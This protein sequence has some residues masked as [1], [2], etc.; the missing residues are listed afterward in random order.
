MTGTNIDVCV[1]GSFMM[2]FVVRTPRRPGLGET[3]V[4]T[5]FELCLGGKGFNQAVAAA[6]SGAATAMVGRVGDDDFGRDFLACLEREGIES[7]VP[8]DTSLGTG[9]GAPVVDANGDNAIVIV[10]RANLAVTTSQIEDASAL[11]ADARVLLLQLEL[12]RDAAVAAA[13]IAREAGTVV[14]LN[15]A[16]AIDGIE[17]FAGLVDVL[18]PNEAEALTL[19][20]GTDVG[21]T[22]IEVGEH[23]RTTLG[24]EVILTLGSE[25]VVVFA[26]ASPVPIPGHA[27][28]S[29]DSVGAGDAFCG[30]LGASLARGAG[31]LEAATTANAAGALAVTRRGAEPSMPT[32]S[33]IEQLLA[34]ASAEVGVSS[35][36]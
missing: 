15:P 12:P 31:L 27:V 34:P 30:A 4:G 36:G 14:V 21:G 29:I 26:D 35:A 32:A 2:D 17:Q 23:L 7:A 28:D 24:S 25:G 6:R 20:G 8:V 10:P 33:A 9:I 11:I 18:V 5:D 16:P 1:V 13:R 3:V 19:A 22:C